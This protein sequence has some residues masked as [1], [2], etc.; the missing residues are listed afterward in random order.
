MKEILFFE[1]P[2]PIYIMIIIIVAVVLVICLINRYYS[3]KQGKQQ[4]IDTLING[5]N[6]VVSLS[7]FLVTFT[8]Y[9][10]Q[11]STLRT[12]NTPYLYLTS[13]EAHIAT[14]K[15]LKKLNIRNPVNAKGEPLTTLYYYGKQ[16]GKYLDQNIEDI[17]IELLET[18][19]EDRKI[20][21]EIRN[22][23]G[24]IC[25]SKINEHNCILVI[26]EDIKSS[27]VL[28]YSSAQL[29]IKNYGATC[30]NLQ[31]ESIKIFFNKEHGEEIITLNSKGTKQKTIPLIIEPNEVIPLIYCQVT[32]NLINAQCVTGKEIIS[33][34]GNSYNVLTKRMPDNA[35]NYDKMEMIVTC[36]NF[37]G[38]K[39]K[40]KLTFEKEGYYYISKTELL[41]K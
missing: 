29:K 39:F 17:G 12:E 38:E 6:V 11:D 1:V 34:L 28:E 21:N 30:T 10:Y 13:V 5:I 24:S 40:Y 15:E 25:F 14:E 32:H 7:L 16:E 22:N 9:K 37:M 8:V 2:V 41:N 23:E 31:L 35:L 4:L 36:E 20:I 3:K 27:F 19:S 26:N 18:N 33:E